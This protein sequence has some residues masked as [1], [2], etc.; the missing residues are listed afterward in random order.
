MPTEVIAGHLDHIEHE[1]PAHPPAGLYTK[2]YGH[3]EAEFLRRAA[4]TSG[5]S[6]SPGS[7][8]LAMRVDARRVFRHYDDDPTVRETVLDA[9]REAKTHDW[10]E[11][12]EVDPQSL[13]ATIDPGISDDPATRAWMRSR[14]LPLVVRHN[15]KDYISEGVFQVAAAIMDGDRKMR[16]RWFDLDA[17]TAWRPRKPPPVEDWVF[18]RNEPPMF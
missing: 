17:G 13:T 14:G 4:G 9:A 16:V 11:D 12:R 2:P 10:F 3:N 18:R 15:G 5:G 7:D 8:E 1:N 6:T